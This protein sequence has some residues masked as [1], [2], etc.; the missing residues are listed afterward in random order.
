[1]EAAALILALGV[2]IA[3]VMGVKTLAYQ[4]V[5]HGLTF[6][7]LSGGGV[8]IYF[9]EQKGWIYVFFGVALT[10]LETICFFVL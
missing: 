1:M 4:A 7:F 9:G 5:A 6:S 10:I 3:R 2:G 8:A